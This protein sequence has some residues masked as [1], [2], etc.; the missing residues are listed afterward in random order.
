MPLRRQ[1]VLAGEPRQDPLV[2]LLLGR[3]T[4]VPDLREDRVL[5]VGLAQ[6]QLEVCGEGVSVWCPLH[7]TGR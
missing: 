2:E 7:G 5:P 6:E 3:L 4:G 1:F